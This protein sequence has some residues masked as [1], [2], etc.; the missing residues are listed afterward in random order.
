M[1][2][3]K[4]PRKS[5]HAVTKEERALLEGGGGELYEYVVSLGS[6]KADDPRLAP[7]APERPSVDLLLRLGLLS[8]DSNDDSYI[9]TDP[10]IIASQ[11]IAP[12][13]QKGA[14]LIQE[15]SEWA[16][17][18]SG[19]GLTWRRAPATRQGPFT[20]IHGAENINKFIRSV[21]DD[22]RTELLTAA[23]QAGRDFTE[24]KEGVAR[25]IDALDRGVA[26]RTLYQHSA[27]RNKTLQTYVGAV[28]PHG[29]EVRTLDEFF[30]RLIVIDRDIAF[31]P[32]PTGGRQMAIAVREPSVVA[33]LVDVFERS[34]ERAR[35]FTNREAGVVRDIATE[36]REMTI[37]ML[38]EGHSDPSAAKRLGV[39]P[40][41]YAGYVADLKVEYEAETRFQLGYAMGERDSAKGA[42]SADTSR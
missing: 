33:Y 12:M 18:F 3:S 8:H 2:Q 13:G 22:A 25:T 16:R 7:D 19:L 15:S 11:V 14:E 23:P 42:D 39:S 10:S 20:E 30:N 31:I 9:P 28:S 4:Q 21:V 34:W 32:G 6:I 35:P 1:P 38:K 24:Y 37:R 41:T 5:D 27:R 26:M 40:R 36:Q 29:A 17:T